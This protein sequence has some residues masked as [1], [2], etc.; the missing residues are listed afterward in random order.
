M[1]VLR[2]NYCGKPQPTF[3]ELASQY[4]DCKVNEIAMVGDDLINDIQGAQNMG[5]TTFLVKT[6]KFR[7]SIYRS[8]SIR[9]DHLLKS[10][11]ELPNYINK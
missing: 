3:F 5:Y 2:G 1:F 8:S 7:S 9:P 6:G 11:G 4:F 10:I